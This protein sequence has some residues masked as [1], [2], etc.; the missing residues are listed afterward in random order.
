M[1]GKRLPQLPGEWIFFVRLNQEQQPVWCVLWTSL[2][3]AA[4]HAR[5]ELLGDAEHVFSTWRHATVVRYS[6]S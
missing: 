3:C 2:A 5:T 4:M 1:Y 6:F